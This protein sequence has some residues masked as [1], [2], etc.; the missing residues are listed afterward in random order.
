[1]GVYLNSTGP[2]MLFREEF[3]AAYFVDKS[4]LIKELVPILELEKTAADSSGQDS[5]GSV[6]FLCITRPRRFGKTVIANMISSYFGK[7]I[8]SSSVFGK[9]ITFAYLQAREFYEIRLEERSSTG[10]ADYIFY[11]YQKENDGIIIE[12]KV[13]ASADQAIQ[14]IKDRNYALNFN[15]KPG[16]EPKCT[17]RILAVGITYSRKDPGKKHVCKVE[18]LR[19]KICRHQQ[20]G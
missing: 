1:M 13:D 15:G 2:Y 14:Q 5:S 12:L 20:G 10:Y 17:G 3:S 16:E 9:W 8:D 18:I 7:G 19:E 4:E 11:P 6:R